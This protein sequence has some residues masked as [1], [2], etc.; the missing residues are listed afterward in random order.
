MKYPK[1]ATYE[2]L[3]PRYLN[4]AKM[5]EFISL[6]GPLHGASVVDLCGGTGRLA[7]FIC[8]RNPT[9]QC[10]L[11]DASADMSM[12]VPL[13]YPVSLEVLDAESFLRY[14]MNQYSHIYCQQAI[15]YWFEPLLMQEVFRVLKPGGQFIFNT[16]SRCPPVTPVTKRYMEKIEGKDV[17]FLEISWKD[18]TADVVHH[19][20]IREGY[21]PHTTS[22]QWIPAEVFKE[23][24]TAAGF[25]VQVIARGS[26]LTFKAV[27]PF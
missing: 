4:L 1:G 13:K 15:N 9:A 25:L 18:A 2:A 14:T 23:S 11:V 17:E 7:G 19:V 27:K 24:L 20:Q 3:Y 12:E 21:P 22:F 8:E 26:S 6:G 10:V 5:E 16:F